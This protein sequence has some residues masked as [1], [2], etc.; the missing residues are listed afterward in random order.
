MTEDA[1]FYEVEKNGDVA[2][3]WLKTQIE[4]TTD[5]AHDSWFW[6]HVSGGLNYQV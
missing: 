1:I 6:T 5:F 4:G 2:H 3:S